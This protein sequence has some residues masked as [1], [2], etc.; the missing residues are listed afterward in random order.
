LIS[1]PAGLAK[2][3]HLKFSLYT[4]SGAFIWVSIL[5][6]IGYYIGKNDALIKE[7]AN[8][9]IIDVLAASFILVALYVFLHRRK[10]ARARVG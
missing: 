10:L 4:L 3:N 6:W 9:A 8:Q 5:T 2:M 1:I 7:Y